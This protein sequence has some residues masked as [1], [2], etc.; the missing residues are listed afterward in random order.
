MDDLLKIYNHQAIE[1]QI[2]QW[3]ESEGFFKPEKSIELGITNEKSDRFCITIPLPNVTGQLHLGH[4]ITISLEDLM[5]RYE[6]MRH[7]ITLYIPG[8][9]HAGIATQNVVERE[10]LKQGIKRKELGREKFV[11]QVWKWKEKYHARI[12]TQSKSLG[13]SSDWAREHFTL[14]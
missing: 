4:A 10:L 3:W 2:Y 12:T 1:R 8:T 5:T 13:I 7:K 14:N 11:E 9:D 6:R